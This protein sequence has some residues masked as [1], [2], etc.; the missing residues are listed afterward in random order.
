M[1][2]MYYPDDIGALVEKLQYN[3]SRADHKP[4]N[5]IKAHGKKF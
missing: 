2:G 5:R 4:E 3:D 1:I